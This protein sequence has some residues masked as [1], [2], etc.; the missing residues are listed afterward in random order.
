M[1]LAVIALVPRLFSAARNKFLPIATAVLCLG[2]LAG[3]RSATAFAAGLVAIVIGLS[4]SLWF[5]P[6]TQA[7]GRVA[8]LAF[9]VATTAIASVVAFQPDLALGLLGRSSTL[10]GRTDFWPYLIQAIGDRPLLGYGYNA[11]FG[12]SVGNEYLSYYV[13]E[14]GGWTPYH[15]HD[16][17]LQIAIDGGFIGLG[18]LAAVLIGAIVRC[19]R[20]IARQRE[21]AAA[22]PLMVVLFLTLGSYTETYL[23]NCN[24]FEWIFFVAAILYP[25][26]GRAAVGSSTPIR[27]AP[28]YHPQ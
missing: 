9:A 1:V 15:A 25:I 10:T 23:G 6:R 5:S 21:L 14:A 18:L 28:H 2:L 12:S 4:A 27:F 13:V 22:W 16:T 24:T 8:I 26:R 19:W 20:Y 3:S 11:F 7:S 17:F